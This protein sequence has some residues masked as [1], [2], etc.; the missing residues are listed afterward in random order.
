MPSDWSY[1]SLVHFLALLRLFS[2]LGNIAGGCP[3][4]LNNNIMVTTVFLRGSGLPLLLSSPHEFHV[5]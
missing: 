2:K 1:V 3:G 5:G 4:T